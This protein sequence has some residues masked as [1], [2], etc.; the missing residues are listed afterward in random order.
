M[1]G[2]RP[3]Q[4]DISRRRLRWRAFG[5]WPTVWPCAEGDARSAAPDSHVPLPLEGPGVLPPR[6]LAAPN[7]DRK[8]PG[9]GPRP[10]NAGIEG[11]ASDRPTD[12]KT[13]PWHHPQ[14]APGRK[15]S[16]RALTEP[17]IGLRDADRAKRRVPEALAGPSSEFQWR[18]I[19]NFVQPWS[20]QAILR[21][22]KAKTHD[23]LR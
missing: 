18:K 2:S 7:D 17:T 11:R 10:G 20:K 19:V 8:L 14:R 13:P 12:R 3:L 22:L 9:P 16:S 15:P 6:T 21:S 4:S 1:R 5:A 23:Y